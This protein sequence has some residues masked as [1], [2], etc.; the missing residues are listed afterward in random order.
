MPAR[1]A[2]PTASYACSFLARCYSE[3]V[4]D[5]EARDH[6]LVQIVDAAMAEAARKAGTWLACRPGCA[7][8]CIGPFSITLLDAQR[9]RRGL[10]EL[11]VTDP[12]RAGR[13]LANILTDE[14][15]NTGVYYDDKGRPMLGSTLVRD[16]K[17]Q[18]CVVVE[19]RALLATA[20]A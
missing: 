11:D 3:I 20:G 10:S 13:V 15:R 1:Y 8:C 6:Q 17:F 7:E 16:P 9:L 19:T 2:G 4:Q 12:E 5:I 14:S 18:D